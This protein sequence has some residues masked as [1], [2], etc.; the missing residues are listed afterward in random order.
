[1]IRITTTS[2]PVAVLDD[3]CGNLVQ[4]ASFTAA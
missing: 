4:M 1:M 3:S 2:V